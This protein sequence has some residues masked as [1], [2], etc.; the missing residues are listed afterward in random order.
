MLRSFSYN[1]EWNLEPFGVNMLISRIIVV[2]NCCTIRYYVR[3]V[4]SCPQLHM[5]V[6]NLIRI[7]SN[8]FILQCDCVIQFSISLSLV[9]EEEEEAIAMAI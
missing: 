3:K 4:L 9:L 1:S 8:T 2:G 7:T 6:Y 5:L